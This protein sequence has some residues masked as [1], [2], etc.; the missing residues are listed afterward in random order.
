[1]NAHSSS[2]SPT[3]RVKR[4]MRITQKSF[5]TS[6]NNHKSFIIDS[7]L[8]KMGKYRA[9]TDNE[10]TSRRQVILDSAE[11][12]MDRWSYDDITMDR[13]AEKSE[14]SKGTLYLYFPSKESIFFEVFDQLMIRW[15]L[16]I[17]RQLETANQSLDAA[18]AAL[19]FTRSLSERPKLVRLYAL[20]H[21]IL[22]TNIDLATATAFQHRRHDRLSSTSVLLGEK[23]SVLTTDRAFE[24]LVALDP[25]ISGFAEASLLSP[26]ISRA[27]DDEG[28]SRLRID[29]AQVFRSTLTAVLENYG[30]RSRSAE[31]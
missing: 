27:L 2:A 14:L 31:R 18:R 30:R 28:L 21:P 19:I 29:V 5:E 9:T 11:A 10:K 13:V 25:I 8:F 3:S 6:L 20:L 16:A 12:L 22:E 17:D 24:F 7:R 23:V 4:E 1:M 15:H 26:A